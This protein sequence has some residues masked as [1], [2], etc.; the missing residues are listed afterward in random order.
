[1]LSTSGYNLATREPRSAQGSETKGEM[2]QTKAAWFVIGWFSLHGWDG[3]NCKPVDDERGPWATVKRHKL[4]LRWGNSLRA[5]TARCSSWIWFVFAWHVKAMKTKTAL[6]RATTCHKSN[7]QRYSKVETN[8]A[9]GRWFLFRLFKIFRH[10]QSHW[11]SERQDAWNPRVLF[12]FDL[13]FQTIGAFTT[14]TLFKFY[15]IYLLIFQSKL[16]HENKP[17][18]QYSRHYLF[19]VE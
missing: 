10:C 5:A 2:G 12:C 7:D 19:K 9:C 4:W 17:Y 3:D 1:M 15:F 8:L 18:T 13:F 6:L 14:L 11:F 16:K